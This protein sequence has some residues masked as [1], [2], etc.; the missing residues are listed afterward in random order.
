MILVTGATGTIGSRVVRALMEAGCRVRAMSREPARIKLSGV[1]TVYGDFEDPASLAVP[2]RNVH[3]VFLASG[4]SSSLK[5]PGVGAA[6]P[7][8]DRALITAAAEAGVRKIVK[9]SNFGTG[10]DA[11]PPLGNWHGPGEDALRAS[12]MA[13]TFLRPVAFAS[14][15]MRW[16]PGIRSSGEV[17]SN[18]GNGKQAI[19]D[20]SDVAAV[21]ALALQYD[22]HDGKV[23]T[24]TG[25]EL[26]SVSDQAVVLTRLLG[27]PIRV[28]EDALEQ[29]RRAL[30][31]GGLDAEGV[32][33][34]IAGIEFIRS[35][36]CEF[37]TDDVR[38][39]TARTPLSFEQWAQNNLR[40]LL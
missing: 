1:E 33:S 38:R 28:V 32:E 15:V 35:G 39:V 30:I 19:I 40:D 9:L 37:L 3:A 27:S 2:L 7:H 10:I 21:A 5:Y 20:P 4:G 6:I 31:A 34:M 24:L 17:H 36:K 25:P 16:I 12:H 13:W 22:E 23:Y 8:H 29:T 14:N 18:T 11:H 26:L